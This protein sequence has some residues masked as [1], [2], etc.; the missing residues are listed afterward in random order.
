MDATYKILILGASYG[1]LLG[2]K[3]AL[4]GH[5]VKLICLPDEARLINEEGARV[6]MPG[7]GVNGLVEL[8]TQKMS[9]QLSASGP[10]DVDPA[11]Y[12]LGRLA[13]QQPP[14]WAP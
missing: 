9:G 5:T 8:D 4:A 1:S 2:A 6:R 3:L 13:I 11:D 10:G 14:Y 12:D 7:R